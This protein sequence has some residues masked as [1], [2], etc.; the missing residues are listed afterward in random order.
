MKIPLISMTGNFESTL[1][2][3][4]DFIISTQVSAEACPMGLAPTTSTTK[5]LALGDAMAICLLTLNGFTKE[6]F[7]E[8]HPSGLLGRRL[9]TFVKDVMTSKDL[10]TIK[11]NVSIKDALSIIASGCMG[12]VLVMDNDNLKGVFTDGDLRRTLDKDNIDI[13]NTNIKEV[14]TTSFISTESSVLAIDALNIMEVNKIS[15]LPVLEKGKLVGVISLQALLN[16][17]IV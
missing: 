14:M 9:L 10:P 16:S 17:G 1:A 5:T 4:S 2:R 12:I 8:T 7:A 11:E 15:A 13:R 3:S 6:K